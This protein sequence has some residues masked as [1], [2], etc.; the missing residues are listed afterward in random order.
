M[1]ESICLFCT[2][3]KLSFVNIDKYEILYTALPPVHYIAKHVFQRVGFMTTCISNGLTPS[4]FLSFLQR[5]LQE[6]SLDDH[7][8][9]AA[10]MLERQP[11]L[12]FDLLLLHQQRHLRRYR[13]YR[14]VPVVS[15][16]T[17]RRTGRGNAVAKTLSTV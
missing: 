12:I 8:R 10:G 15:A 9:L 11:G 2:L 6:M 7:R 4:Y 3:M 14:G 1:L 17:C 13:G 5:L 16:E